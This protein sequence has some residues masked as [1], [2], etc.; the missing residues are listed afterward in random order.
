MTNRAPLAA[1]RPS[2]PSWRGRGAY[3][4]ALGLVLALAFVA[5]PAAAQ[6]QAPASPA[7]PPLPVAT[8]APALRH[9]PV[10]APPPAGAP[11]RAAARGSAARQAVPT[12]PPRAPAQVGLPVDSVRH[13]AAAARMQPPTNAVAQCKDGTFI[14]S[15]A[16]T[17]GCATHRGLLVTMPPRT[18]PPAPS[19]TTRVAVAPMAMQAAAPASA[20]APPAGATMRCKDGSYLAGTPAPGACAANGGL[21]AVLPAP[22]TPPPAPA[23]LRRP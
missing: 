11:T 7:P 18:T 20:A 1:M 22:R 10:P 4:G 14:V 6:A 8:P 19:A 2:P 13:V 9:P 5:A 15:P 21:A 16:T 17:S 23:L 12:V 3:V